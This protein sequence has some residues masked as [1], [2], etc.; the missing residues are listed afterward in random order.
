MTN[1]NSDH[2]KQLNRIR[3]IRTGKSGLDPADYTS[4]KQ[5]AMD[6]IE[7]GLSPQQYGDGAQSIAGRL[8][9]FQKEVLEDAGDF[10]DGEYSV[11]FKFTIANPNGKINFVQIRPSYK[12]DYYILVVYDPCMYGDDLFEVFVCKSKDLYDLLPEF[13]G[14]AHG[15]VKENGQIT[16]ENIEKKLSFGCEYA[17]RPNTRANADK[18][19]GKLLKPCRLMEEI[20]KI[21]LIGEERWEKVRKNLI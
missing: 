12:I 19:S 3:S 15:T 8:C 17:L 6:C 10:R 16:Q 18:K 13:G 7:Y 4:L 11:E 14:Y 2:Q 5:Y 1:N 21:N 9:N 20:R